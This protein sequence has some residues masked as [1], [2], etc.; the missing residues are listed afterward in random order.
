M[1]AAGRKREI[2]RAAGHVQVA[3]LR[4]QIARGCD[5][6]IT[7]AMMLAVVWAPLARGAEAPAAGAA[8]EELIFALM[9]LWAL[10]CVLL[11]PRIAPGSAALARLAA[12]IVVFA[13][14]IALQLVPL[15]PAVMKAVSGSTY[16]LYARM[17]SSPALSAAYP[18]GAHQY[19][20]WPTLA[21]AP[22]LT[23]G[24][25]L[26]VLAYLCVL[27]LV[28]GYPL[29]PAAGGRPE[30][31][32]IGALVVAVLVSALLAGVA[33]ASSL[34]AGHGGAA[35]GLALAH[36]GQGTFHNPDHF[37]DYLVLAFPMAV[38]GVLS[39][40]SFVPRRW[41]EAFVVFATLVAVV[42]LVG[43][44]IS[45]SRAAWMAAALG[46]AAAAITWSRRRR[47]DQGAQGGRQRLVMARAA[48]AGGLILM[49]A[50]AVV[51]TPA[52][53]RIG[54]RLGETAHDESVLDRFAVWSDSL[55]MV[56][57]FPVWGVGLGGWP[58]LFTRYDRAPWDPDYFWRETH[59]DYLQILEEAGAIGFVLAAW[60]LLSQVRA[61]SRARCAVSSHRLALVAAAIAA[62]VGAAVH[63]LFD[64]SLQVPANALLLVV[65]L[66]LAHRQA[67]ED[68]V[69]WWPAPAAGARRICWIT[70]AAATAVLAGF[71]IVCAS[72]HDRK[73]YPYNLD[74]EI[75]AAQRLAPDQ[76][77]ARMAALIRAY[78]AHGELHLALAQLLLAQNK[79]AAAR[80][81][82]DTAV[83]LA[84]ANPDAHDALA[85]LLLAQGDSDESLREMTRSVQHSP[86]PSTHDF[87]RKS[88]LPTLTDAQV[89]AVERGYRLALWNT[90]AVYGLGYFYDRL[91]RP[92]ERGSL[93]ESAARR[94]ADPDTRFDYLMKAGESY[95]AADE[96][97][98]ADTAL[99]RAAL[100]RRESPRPY[101]K[102]AAFYASRRDLA[103]A[104]AAIREGIAA[105][106]D[107]V[108]LNIA[109]AQAAAKAGDKAQT[110]E[111]LNKA[112]DLRPSAFDDNLLIGVMYLDCEDWKRAIGALTAAVAANP[113]AADGYYYLGLAQ[114]N[115]YDFAG[116]A[117]AFQRALDIAP[118]RADI[119]Q[120]F[121][122]FQRVL[123]RSRSAAGRSGAL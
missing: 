77:A 29:E 120:A 108:A 13:A 94:E 2:G 106:A 71:L 62:A 100:L 84:P 90:D 58:E 64:F 44:V 63:E 7:G 83:W 37:A 115:N 23:R 45:L 75:D 66:G 80:H 33:G 61:L 95:I 113:Q 21:L 25:L 123:A 105:G 72:R 17:M 10:K 54:T 14:Y 89:Q 5:F 8:L 73:P 53:V 98:S 85:Q 109:L 103:R 86:R 68:G 22:A 39:P 41:R 81:E 97:A 26:K 116:A 79:T 102:L 18:A 47:R 114:Q 31:G 92:R 96:P 50:V 56:R 15:T 87:L 4:E 30:R 52:T 35:G 9:M 69:H 11:Q 42:C 51:G 78:P 3:P 101:R 104:S 88:A 93:Y 57:D 76:G 110:L 43:L 111:A 24:A 20:P 55:A 112:L 74:A 1:T 28:A 6:A 117:S 12:P 121:A 99:H 36:R 65:I 19:P 48:V 122:A 60:I 59:N 16:E 82:L 107:P 91:A 49:L 40:E 34:F 119:K 46:L 67:A 32:F 70:G 38:A 27:L 118:Q